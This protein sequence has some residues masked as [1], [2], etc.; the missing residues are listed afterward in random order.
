M[1]TEQFKSA[2]ERQGIKEV[3]RDKI[4]GD[5]VFFADG[6]VE[7]DKVKYLEFFGLPKMGND[8]PDGCYATIWYSPRKLGWSGIGVFEPMHDIMDTIEGRKGKRINT[9]RVMAKISLSKN[10]AKKY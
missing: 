2:L 4:E 3:C 8:Y 6:F 7:K 1:N 5:E 10:K 9:L